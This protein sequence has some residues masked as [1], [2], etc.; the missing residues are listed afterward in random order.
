MFLVLKHIILLVCQM[1]ILPCSHNLIDAHLVS[2]A[3]LFN[4]TDGLKFVLGLGQG[5]MHHEV[6]LIIIIL[7]IVLLPFNDDILYTDDFTRLFYSHFH[8]QQ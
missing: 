7:N 8:H 4:H 2:N 6:P 3:N 1:M 5:Y